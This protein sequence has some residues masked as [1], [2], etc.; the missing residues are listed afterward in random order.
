MSLVDVAP[1]VLATLGLPPLADATGRP[2]S[3]PSRAVVSE[4]TAPEGTVERALH[5][6]DGVHVLLEHSGPGGRA[7]E[8]FDLRADPGE[9]HLLAPDGAPGR[10]L[11]AAV[12]RFEREAPPVPP[13]SVVTP[14][15]QFLDRLRA[16]GYVQ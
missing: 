2:L 12:E 10:D 1:T 5:G 4:E 9:A 3:T 15:R 11:V 14:D 7:I 6:D 8:L 13:G 16:L